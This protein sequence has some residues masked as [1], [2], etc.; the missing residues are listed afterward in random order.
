M[1]HIK[2]IIIILSSIFALLLLSGFFY[3]YI[4]DTPNKIVQKYFNAIY[5]G[6]FEVAYNYINADDR[7]ELSYEEYLKENNF[8]DSIK[9]LILSKSSAKAYKTEVNQNTAIVFVWVSKPDISSKA[10]ELMP[11]LLSA[12]FSDKSEIS[13]LEQK[14]EKI[15]NEDHL[16]LETTEEKIETIKENGKWYINFNFRKSKK[17]NKLLEEAKI[18]EKEKKFN[19]AKEKYN[20]A[21]LLKGHSIEIEDKIKQ[22]D[23]EIEAFEEK[24]A[25]IKNIVL[26]N[27][28]VSDY[29]EYSFSTIEKAFFGTL[30][31]NGDKIL[32]SI[33]LTVYMYD[34][35]GNVIAEEDFYPLYNYNKPFK[36]KF[37]KDF[38]WKLTKYAPSN[39]SGKIKVEVTDIKF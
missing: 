1:K 7:K 15:L 24:Q 29:Q 21:L 11:V 20:E 36:P 2:K 26:K 3:F 31:N 35:E 17:I 5:S 33:T 38:G 18:Y 8:T 14:F 4:Q 30:V 6:N 32:S 9:K 25:Y 27:V 37:V 39:W 12:A 23:E 34:K 16:P 28:E 22:L 10:L 19:L 13:K